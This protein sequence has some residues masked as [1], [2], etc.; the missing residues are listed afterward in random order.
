MGSA[1]LAYGRMRPATAWGQTL[2]GMEAGIGLALMSLLL[3]C[4]VRKFSR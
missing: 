1:R 4:I 2:A 3:V